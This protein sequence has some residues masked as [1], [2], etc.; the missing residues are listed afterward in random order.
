VTETAKLK[1]GLE[2]PKGSHI[3]GRVTDVKLKA[4]KD[5]PSKLGLLFDKAQLKDGKE[6]PIALALVSIA[7]PWGRGSANTAALDNGGASGLRDGERVEPA[8][9]NGGNT[10][11]ASQ[12]VTD[13]SMRAGVCY[14]HDM[15]I[16][17]YSM[18]T[19]GT[20]L[21]SSKTTVYLDSGTRLLLL[22]Q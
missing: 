13:D 6:I 12:V 18:G 19:P 1:D 14:L 3:L 22:P 11:G 20:I 5:G 9:M 16:A 21:Q 7:P 10:G 4:D 2:L 15:T 17:T 8:G